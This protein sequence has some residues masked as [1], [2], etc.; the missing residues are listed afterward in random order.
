MIVGF[1]CDFFGK[2]MLNLFVAFLFEGTKFELMTFFL[3]PRMKQGFEGS[4]NR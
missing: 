1:F 3:C 2:V 4:Q